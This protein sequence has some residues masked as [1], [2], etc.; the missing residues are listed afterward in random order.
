MILVFQTT[1]L[2]WLICPSKC[3]Y[4][5]G[6]L[7]KR[8]HSPISLYINVPK[9]WE[10]KNNPCRETT[11]LCQIK[12]GVTGLK[13]RKEWTLCRRRE[14]LK[15]YAAL[16]LFRLRR[17]WLVLTWWNPAYSSLHTGIQRGKC[18][19]EK[20]TFPTAHKQRAQDTNPWI[21][22]LTTAVSWS[23]FLVLPHMQR[24]REPNL[25]GNPYAQ[26]KKACLLKIPHHWVQPIHTPVNTTV[27]TEPN[28]NSAHLL[29]VT[30]PI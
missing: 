19:W 1:L 7:Q 4:T 26:E 8:Y 10:K 14:R 13:M 11:C 9:S 12:Y 16:H 24:R 2:C 25:H 28:P 18:L 22:Y 15:I 27:T 29:H 5:W 17:I 3:H 21:W 6:D 23:L 30:C 20:N